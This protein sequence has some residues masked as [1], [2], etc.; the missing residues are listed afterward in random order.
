MDFRTFYIK[1]TE[2]DRK[3]LLDRLSRIAKQY[4]AKAI[5]AKEDN[6][7]FCQYKTACERV[8]E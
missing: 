1:I 8:G 2:E 7:F 4:Y 6:C 3:E 5:P